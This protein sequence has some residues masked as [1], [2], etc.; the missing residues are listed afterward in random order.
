MPQNM[1]RRMAQPPSKVLDFKS[2]YPEIWNGFATLAGHCH[3]S[4]GPLD[5]KARKLAKLGLAI[6]TRHEG[7]VHSADIV[8]RTADEGLGEPE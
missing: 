7:A 8:S 3:E 4:V 5:Q 2:R 6:G 1:E